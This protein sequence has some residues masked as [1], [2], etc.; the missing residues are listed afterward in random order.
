MKK[1]SIDCGTNMR[2]EFADLAPKLGIDHTWKVFGFEPNVYAIKWHNWQIPQ[3][4]ELTNFLCSEISS[5]DI[6]VM[7]WG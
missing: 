3:Y 6:Q 5:L 2:M 7:G 1:V 4:D